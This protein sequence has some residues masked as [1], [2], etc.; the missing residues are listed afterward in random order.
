[1]THI[2]FNGRSR[3]GSGSSLLKGVLRAATAAARL[4]G[5]WIAAEIDRR[6]T[7]QLLGSDA[8]L[9]ADIGI[10]RADVQAAVMSAAGEKASNHLARLR[11][12]RR[13]A[14]RAQARES[15]Q[16]D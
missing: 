10:T 11:T 12:E 9:L 4:V 8:R 3:D 6:R 5:Q 13:S 14:E 2:T 16:A 15:R 7:L 1:M